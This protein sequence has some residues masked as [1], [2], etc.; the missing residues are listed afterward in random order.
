MITLTENDTMTKNTVLAENHSVSNNFFKSD[1][2]LQ[3]YLEKNL[4][5]EGLSYMKD[6]LVALGKEAA[7]KMDSLSLKA[8][9]EGPKL[10][11]RDKWGNTINEIEFHPSYDALM[12]IAIDSEM[13]KVK[14]DPFLRNQFSKE[15][16][17]LGFSVGYL[18][19]LAETG[20]F[21][22]L[23]MTDGVAR[24]IDRFCEEGDKERLLKHIYSTNL[25]Q[26]YTGAMFL[27]EKAGGS[28][29]GSNI[30]RAEK[31]NG[32]TYKLYGE[33]WFC[34]N[35]NAEIIFA[36]ARTD[37]SIEGTRGLSI[38]LVEK[39]LKDGSKNPMD[40]IRL[41]D[42]LGVR[43]MASAECMLD[44][45]IGILVGEE[46]K[47][48]KIMTEMI[49]VSRLYNSVAAL[50]CARRALI[51]AYNFL[52]FR[53]TFGKNAL[54]HALI[55]QKLHELGSLHVAGFYLTWRAIQALDAADNG[56]NDEAEL[57]R[58][59]TPMVK[60]W[61]AEKGVY[62]VRESMELM[63]GMGYIEDTVV[64]K[65]MRDVM[66]LPIWEGA[67]N[68]MILDMLRASVKSKGYLKL[69]EEI[70]KNLPHCTYEKERITAKYNNLELAISSMIDYDQEKLEVASKVNFEKLTEFYQLSLLLSV[71]DKQAEEW[72]TPTIRFFVNKLIGIDDDYSLCSV[73]KTDRLIGWKIN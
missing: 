10:I 5:T 28:D 69:T 37:S 14:W 51:E 53:T 20:Q 12:Q 30:V 54:E 49:N 21:C 17:H 46:F 57:L 4:S 71:N 34:S 66:V 59:L 47:G 26:F 52:K 23:C 44:E 41:K 27:T 2:I 13:F 19:G 56:N 55:R 62:V 22:P 11:K 8:D 33:K 3:H 63:G 1:L 67:G 64:P 36:L 32:T 35:A 65:I 38:F 16:H 58:F 60:K 43:S 39:T 25:D 68:I 72:I 24:L 15:L 50:S 70:R 31:I 61:T 45:T 48:F 29:V 42:K 6:K 40:I 73:E 7:T 9:K 18:Y